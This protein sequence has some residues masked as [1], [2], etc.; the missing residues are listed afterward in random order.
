[1]P[2]V[3]SNIFLSW[4][5]YFSISFFNLNYFLIRKNNNFNFSFFILKKN[6]DPSFIWQHFGDIL[7][8]LDI[9]WPPLKEMP[10]GRPSKP[11]K[12]IGQLKL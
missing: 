8:L 6:Y 3:V 7:Q 11:N 10:E 2:I 12:N 9:T 1:M 5:I 4:V